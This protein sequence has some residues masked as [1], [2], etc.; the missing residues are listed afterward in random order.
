MAQSVLVR[1]LNQT[2]IGRNFAVQ[3]G[4]AMTYGTLGAIKVFPTTAAVSLAG[5]NHEDLI[6]QLDQTVFLQ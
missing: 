4:A 1:D 5:V 6:L 3:Y 2:H